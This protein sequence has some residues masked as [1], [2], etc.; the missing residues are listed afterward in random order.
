L[1]R[2]GKES[3]ALPSFFQDNPWL[4]ILAQ[5]GVE[6][7]PDFVASRAPSTPVVSR[8][9]PVI[10]PEP[11]ASSPTT[12]PLAAGFPK[13]LVVRLEV[14]SELVKDIKELKEVIIMA[15][16]MSQRQATVVPIYI[17]INVAQLAPQVPPQAPDHASAEATSE[18]I[19]PRCGRS[20]RLIYN[21]KGR[22]TYILVLHGCQK[23]YLGP[24]D[25]VK[26]KWPYL[27]ERS[28]VERGRRE[29]AGIPSP[30]SLGA[31]ASGVEQC[32][33]ARL[34]SSG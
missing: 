16:S 10:E 27:V 14:P 5:G 25:K 8:A 13:E 31:F 4:D 21:R 18:I 29:Q 23:C 33:T 19:C 3:A 1:A 9:A 17:P 22:R 15:L 6:Q 30:P 11:V 20:G 7:T 32:S 28:L 34:A 26:A 2:R 24:A 12:T